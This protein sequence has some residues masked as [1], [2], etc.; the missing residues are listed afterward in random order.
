MEGA[1]QP[2]AIVISAPPPAPKQAAGTNKP[3]DTAGMHTLTIV[4]LMQRE[5]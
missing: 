2:A 4:Q 3:A 5:K 1:A